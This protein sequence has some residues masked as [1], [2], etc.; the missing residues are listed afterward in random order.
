MLGVVGVGDGTE[1]YSDV[2]NAEGVAVID[3]LHVAS[4]VVP[5]VASCPSLTPNRHHP[6][7]AIVNRRCVA[8]SQVRASA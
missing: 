7:I 1:S 6:R 8:G 5:Y 4:V 2:I 3:V